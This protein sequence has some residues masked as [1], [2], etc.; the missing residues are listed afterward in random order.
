MKGVTGTNCD[1]Q[2]AAGNPCLSNPCY[3]GGTCTNV[4]TTGFA[5]Q[6][7][8]GLGGPQCKGIINSCSCVNGGTCLPSFYNGAI[9][10]ECLCATGFGFVNILIKL[11]QFSNN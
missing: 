2:A 5:C 9:I 1:T 8:V 10:N 4:G 3:N 7:P 11:I 6:C